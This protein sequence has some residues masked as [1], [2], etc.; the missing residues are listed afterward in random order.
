MCA[1]SKLDPVMQVTRVSGPTAGLDVGGFGSHGV[2]LATVFSDADVTISPKDTSKYGAVSAH[3][4]QSL[5][6]TH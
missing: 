2:G 6:M 4:Q 5:S 1:L 3:I